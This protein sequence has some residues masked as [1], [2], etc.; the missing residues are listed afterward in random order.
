MPSHLPRFAAEP[1]QDALPYGRWAERLREELLRAVEELDGVDPAG[2][3]DVR[4]HPDRT[5][6]GRTWIPATARTAEGLELVGFVSFRPPHDEGEEPS[7][8]RATADVTEELAELHPEWKA[9]LTDETV[10]GWRAEKGRVLSM[11]LVFGR[12]LVPGCAYAA[13]VLGDD[14]VDR[15]TLEEGRF[16]LLAPDDPHGH[17]GLAVVLLDPSGEE[18]ARESLYDDDEDDDG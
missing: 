1:P 4:W 15:C 8:F 5:W 6:H 17:D 9:D 13:A 11:T 12:P 18:L 14:V 10:G 2:I 16:T 7:A 3:G